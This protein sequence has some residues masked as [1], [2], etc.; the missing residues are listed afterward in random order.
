M[1]EKTCSKTGR[2]RH[3][4]HAITCKGEQL[5]KTAG[6]IHISLQQHEIDQGSSRT[7]D[8]HPHAHIKNCSEG[9][10]MSSKQALGAAIPRIG[11]SWPSLHPQQ[12]AHTLGMPNTDH[13]IREGTGIKSYS[14]SEQDGSIPRPKRWLTAEKNSRK[15]RQRKTAADKSREEPLQCRGM[16][17]PFIANPIAARQMSRS[18]PLLNPSRPLAT[19][20]LVCQ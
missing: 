12:P 10:S 19:P 15:E 13:E 17:T 2:Q 8:Q 9:S 5:A 7:P 3:C 20:E 11:G 18:Q 6:P 14:A 1:L 16:G 4:S